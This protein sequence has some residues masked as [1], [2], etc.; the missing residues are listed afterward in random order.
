MIVS[1]G[2]S[3]GASPCVGSPGT[4]PSVLSQVSEAAM[5][6]LAAASPGGPAAPSPGISGSPPTPDASSP[7]KPEQPAATRAATP[8]RLF[9]MEN[10][11]SWWL[12]PRFQRVNARQG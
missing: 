7:L 1:Q 2:G 9:H 6:T 12:A 5:Q 3:G 4:W 8:A 11:S 10:A